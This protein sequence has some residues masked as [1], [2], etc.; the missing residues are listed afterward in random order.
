MIKSIP[1]FLILIILSQNLYSQTLAIYCEDKAPAQIKNTDGTLSG[2]VVETVRELQKI[3]GIRGNIEMVPWARG[4]HL[5]ST[6]PDVM[7]FSMTRTKERDKL[8]Y[9]VGPVNEANFY[10][11]AKAASKIKITSL[12]DAKKIN[13]IGVYRNDVRDQMLTKA[14][15]TNLVRSNDNVENINKLMQGRI[16]VY[17]SSNI[18]MPGESL[19][20]GITPTDLKP[21]FLIA[22]AQTYIAVSKGTDPE[23]PKS[24][25]KALDE[26]KMDGS[27]KKLFEKYYQNLELPGPA[28]EPSF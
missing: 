17:V 25:N 10:F 20:A 19:K 11:Y 3:T 4:Y 27:F 23:L 21:L 12:E 15:F 26:M 2:F 14:G 8:F 7:L 9:W 1:F 13:K 18:T 24:L 28:V 22:Q 5:A 6:Y 16:D